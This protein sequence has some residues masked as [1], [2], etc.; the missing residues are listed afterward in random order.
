[1]HLGRVAG[2]PAIPMTHLEAHFDAVH[3]NGGWD[4]A[5]LLPGFGVQFLARAMLNFIEY[6]ILPTNFQTDEY[7]PALHITLKRPEFASRQTKECRQHV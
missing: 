3:S 5:V 2:R 7:R 4:T 1:M 6:E